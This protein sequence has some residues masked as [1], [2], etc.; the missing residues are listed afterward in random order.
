MESSG[1]RSLSMELQHI[2]E[3]IM[4]REDKANNTELVVKGIS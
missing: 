1:H 3:G 4:K 2:I